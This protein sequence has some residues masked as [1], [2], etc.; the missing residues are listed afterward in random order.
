MGCTAAP[1][2]QIVNTRNNMPTT[3]TPEN[4]RFIFFHKHPVSAKTRFLKLAHGGVCGP[5]ALP[6]LSQL[7]EGYER[8]DVK[9]VMHPGVVTEIAA[10]SLGL[11]SSDFV[12]DLTYRQQVEVPHNALTVYLVGFKGHDTP[13]QHLAENDHRFIAITQA[14][15]LPP[16]EMELLRRAYA[17]IMEG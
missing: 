5:E 10:K 8:D 2:Q 17:T 13:D 7:N 12:V 9:V 16:V 4:T 3:I 11:S 15:G 14:F 1:Q 6:T